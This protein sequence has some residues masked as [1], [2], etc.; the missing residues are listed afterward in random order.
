MLDIKFVRENLVKVKKALA[1][2]QTNF[3]LEKVVKLDDERRALQNRVETLRA[4]Q[5]QL[6][7]EGKSAGR[8]TDEAVK[9]KQML[10]DLD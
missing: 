4:Q 9:V 6:A 5:N 2:R 10:K 8:R 1:K 3:D 7:K